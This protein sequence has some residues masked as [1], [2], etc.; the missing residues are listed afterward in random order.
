M[1][2]TQAEIARMSGISTSFMCD[3]LHERK[4]PSAT[5]SEKL[6][7]VTGINIRAWLM[8]HL[9]YNELIHQVMGD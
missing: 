6:E 9:Y 4:K 2:L 3:I 7:R 5:I 1:A 8:P